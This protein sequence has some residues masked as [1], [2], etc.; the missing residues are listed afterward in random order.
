MIVEKE[1]REGGG[2]L[3]VVMVDSLWLVLV[4]H[5]GLMLWMVEGP[6]LW[7]VGQQIIGQCRLAQ[8]AWHIAGSSHV[9]QGMGNV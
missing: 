2:N 9:R 5:C 8:W 1:E 3:V 4:V 6:P 7:L